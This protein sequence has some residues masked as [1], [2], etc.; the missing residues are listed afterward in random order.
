MNQAYFEKI[1]KE[2]SHFDRHLAMNL[3]VHGPGSITYRLTIG[4]HHLSPA[5]A[6]HGGVIVA[7]M[8]AVLGLT[9]LSWAVQHEKLCATVELKN[10]FLSPAKLNDELEGT[11]VIDFIGSK[12]VVTSA[13]IN[14]LNSNRPVAKG[15]GTFTLYPV[16][17]QP[18]LETLL[19]LSAST[20]S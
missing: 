11:G 10:N 18:H 3:T 16:T 20:D 15:M 9:A 17:K 14:D 4:K 7:M 6:C 2:A 19:F 13:T 5:R 8:D 12:L 1:Y